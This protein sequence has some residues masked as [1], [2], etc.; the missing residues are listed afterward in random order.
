[1]SMSL[2]SNAFDCLSEPF[3]ALAAPH[4]GVGTTF[5]AERNP[6]L[7]PLSALD[8]IGAA[9]VKT[10][11]CDFSHSPELRGEGER[12]SSWWLVHA[13]PR[14]EKKLAQDLRA[15]EIAHFLPV[16][17]HQAWTRGRPRVTWVPLFP[18]YLFQHGSVQRGGSSPIY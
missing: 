14:Q 2:I 12:H 11:T 1:M 7:F 18:G 5:S 10:A 16:V 13:K 4:D 3:W 9:S 8:G 15:L 6:Y 17:S